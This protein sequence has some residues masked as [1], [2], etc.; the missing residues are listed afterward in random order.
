[1]EGQAIIMEDTEGGISKVDISKA[2]TTTHT[3]LATIHTV[4]ADLDISSIQLAMH[5][6][7]AVLVWVRY[8]VAAACWI[9]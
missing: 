9:V 5:V 1:M 7:I 4:K 8:A 3:S 6:E 2:L